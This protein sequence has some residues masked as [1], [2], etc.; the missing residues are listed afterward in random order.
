M[1][2]PF[3]RNLARPPLIVETLNRLNR[4]NGPLLPNGKRGMLKAKQNPTPNLHGKRRRHSIV[5]FEMVRLNRAAA[6]PL[7]QQLYRQIR[8]ELVSGTFSNGASRLPSSRALAADREVSPADGAPRRG[9]VQRRREDRS[10][11]RESHGDGARDAARA[12]VR[13]LG[14][15]VVGSVRDRL[16]RRRSAM[17]TD[18][19]RLRSRRRLARLGGHVVRR[20]QPP[21]AIARGRRRGNELGARSPTRPRHE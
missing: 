18:G 19:C 9:V 12:R 17:G 20:R 21:L 1:A 13:E 3:W 2:I 15:L 6:E 5:A 11:V 8:D 14:R 4:K 16:R 7:H 10:R